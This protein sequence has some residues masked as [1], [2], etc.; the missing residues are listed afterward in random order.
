VVALCTSRARSLQRMELQ[1]AARTSNRD[2]WQE[3]EEEESE[4][5]LGSAPAAPIRPRRALAAAATAAALVAT[6]A[7]VARHA[8][9][10][11]TSAKPD[12]DFV[13][14]DRVV[15]SGGNLSSPYRNSLSM[16]HWKTASSLTG[17]DVGSTP[18]PTEAPK[19]THRKGSFLVLGD[20]GFDRWVHGDIRTRHCQQ[21]IADK[22]AETQAQLGDVKF[23]INVG[24]SF[25]PNGLRSNGRG[26]GEDGQWQ[27]KWRDVYSHKLRSV[28]WY[29][30]YGNHDSHADPCSCSD[31]TSACAQLNSDINNL[32]YFYMPD[33]NWYKEHPELDLE[34]VAMDL[35]HYMGGW[36]PNL[37]FEAQ[38]NSDCRWTPCQEKCKAIFNARSLAAFDLFYDRA[39]NSPAKNL[40]VFSH[41]PTDYFSSRPDFIRALSNNSKHHIEYFAGHRHNVDQ[42]STT[43]TAPNNNWLVGGGGGWGCEGYAP[44]NQGF[45]V[46]E[47]HDDGTITTYSVLVDTSECCR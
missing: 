47:I 4:A 22:M 43:S 27:E 28:P 29:S 25:Y 1:P 5:L 14:L 35:N 19:P 9:I 34:V 18:K 17:A 38:S 3:E 41:Y 44:Q 23:V 15:R 2:I 45:V 24:D 26:A 46:G 33:V 8:V 13:G 6:A 31:D 32:D 37:R 11:P 12:S 42:S 16:S 21:V 20:W 36:N 39:R 40:L 30:V 10:V 7:S